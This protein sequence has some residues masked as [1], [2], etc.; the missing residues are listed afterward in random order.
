M[1]ENNQIITVKALLHDMSILTKRAGI[2][3]FEYPFNA[4]DS[5]LIIS[6]A[7]KI[8]SGADKNSQH[9]QKESEY[10]PLRP[11]FNVLNKHNYDRYYSSKKLI[12]GDGINYCFQCLS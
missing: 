1:A 3:E 11:V 2:N 7:E 10:D 9:S 6:A 4:D 5:D 12:A 8:T